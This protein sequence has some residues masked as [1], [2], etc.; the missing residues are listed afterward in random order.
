MK[1][2]IYIAPLSQ[3]LKGALQWSI[4][5]QRT[6]SIYRRKLQPLLS[7]PCM[8]VLILP[9]SEGWKAEWTLA[10]KKFAKYST[11]GRTVNG[12][13]DLRVQR[14]RSY[15]CASPTA[16]LPLKALYAW[17]RE[18]ANPHHHAEN[19]PVQ[20]LPTIKNKSNVHMPHA[21][22][23]FLTLSNATVSRLIEALWLA[24]WVSTILELNW[25]ERFG[26]WEK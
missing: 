14:Q 18:R 17:A 23:L 5:P 19:T 6:G 12:T 3:S 26:N 4:Y 8:L 20:T 7:S 10:G 13:Q 1:W 24:K 9:T 11:L 21:L 22:L 25:C 2:C 16:I 15:H